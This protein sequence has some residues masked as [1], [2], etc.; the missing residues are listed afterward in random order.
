MW[1]RIRSAASD[2]I[3][4]DIR[5]TGQRQA[6]GCEEFF[7]G[8]QHAPFSQMAAAKAGNK[9]MLELIEQLSEC[10]LCCPI[11]LN[12]AARFANTKILRLFMERD[13]KA[14]RHVFTM[15]L[16]SKEMS[17]IKYIEGKMGYFDESFPVEALECD[18][19]EAFPHSRNLC[20][21]LL[22]LTAPKRATACS[23]NSIS[24]T[25]PTKLHYWEPSLQA[26]T[27]IFTG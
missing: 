3:V 4:D 22:L 23:P 7:F 16:K 18:N 24:T 10:H 20:G 26:M 19:L 6:D 27:N 11:V 15:A 1:Y 14:D 12:Y 13:D 5:R 21:L 17:N 8:T 9:K 25:F 2:L